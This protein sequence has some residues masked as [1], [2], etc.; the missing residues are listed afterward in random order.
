MNSWWIP[1]NFPS[2]SGFVATLSP[3]WGIKKQDMSEKHDLMCFLSDCSS[4][5]CLSDTWNWHRKFHQKYC[6][7]NW[8]HFPTD[9]QH[10]CID[11]C[12]ILY[13]EFSSFAK[14]KILLVHPFYFIIHY[15]LCHKFN[16]FH[17]QDILSSLHMVTKPTAEKVLLRNILITVHSVKI[18]WHMFYMYYIT[19]SF[20][21]YTR[22]YQCFPL[23]SQEL[24]NSPLLNVD[25]IYLQISICIQFFQL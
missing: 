5:C 18:M 22:L 10:A 13:T 19:I 16:F 7:C 8:I 4:G 6:Y 11:A 2:K 15:I 25:S 9:I 3:G 12:Y 14:E 20:M 17:G 1:D 23:I 24:Y 21:Q